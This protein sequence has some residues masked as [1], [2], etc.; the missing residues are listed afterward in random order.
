MSTIDG[1]RLKI[2]WAKQHVKNLDGV[3]RV[4]RNSRPY[5]VIGQENYQTTELEWV[6]TRAREIPA[7][8]PLIAGD[9]I[10]NL[11]SALD[12]LACSLV[13]ANG[14]KPIEGVTAFPISDSL[15]KH[16]AAMRGGKV[17]GMSQP[18]IA[19]ID[20]L[21][22]YQGGR[23]TLGRLARM[24]NIDKHRLLLSAASAVISQTLLA[25]HRKQL[26]E[27]YLGSYPNA[28]E[29]PDLGGTVIKPD[30]ARFPLKVGEVFLSLPR[31]EMENNFTFSLGVAFNE[32]SCGLVGDSIL[33]VMTNFVAC[34]EKIVSDFRGFLN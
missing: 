17:E 33:D 4:F 32:P 21:R 7:D 6:L 22:P 3:I 18:A 9:A 27:T 31:A 30:N 10:Q 15:P 24:S 1:I 19:A 28:T 29:L 8:V 20:A 34:V 5:E 25:K 16:Q 13:V 14:R 2:E 26:L 11:R 12:Y 23:V